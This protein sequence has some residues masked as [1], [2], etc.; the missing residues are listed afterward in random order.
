MDAA[1]KRFHRAGLKGVTTELGYLASLIVVVSIGWIPKT[2]IV[3]RQMLFSRQELDVVGVSL[4]CRIGF[5]A[6]H[7]LA[8]KRPTIVVIGLS[9]AGN[10]KLMLMR[11]VASTL[12]FSNQITLASPRFS[13][14]LVCIGC[15]IQ[16][17]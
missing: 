15:S 1:G 16:H 7:V 4:R 3:C 8:F 12:P 17:R 9:E 13:N 2:T 5:N 6:F 10:L 14:G 11:P